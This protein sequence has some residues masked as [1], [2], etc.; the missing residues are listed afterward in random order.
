VKLGLSKH[1]RLK[2]FFEL[3]GKIYPDLVKVFFT[4]LKFKND[5]LLSSI[6]GVPHGDQ[7]KSLE[8]CDRTQINGCAS[9]KR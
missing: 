7:Q 8:R 6:K 2:F 5:V 1:Q 3:S 4:N 9:K